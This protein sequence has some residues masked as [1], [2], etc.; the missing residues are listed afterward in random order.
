MLC[1]SHV[2]LICNNGEMNK[3]MT[4]TLRLALDNWVEFKMSVIPKPK[5]IIIQNKLNEINQS[6]L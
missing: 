2:V 6:Q 5:V 4:N 1:V 3:H